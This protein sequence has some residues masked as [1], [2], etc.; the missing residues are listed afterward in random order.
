MLGL[1]A[2][3]A[4]PIVGVCIASGI[5]IHWMPAT[6]RLRRLVGTGRPKPTQAATWRRLVQRV[7]AGQR[8]NGHAGPP[9]APSVAG[10]HLLRQSGRIDLWRSVR[11][12]PTPRRATG[13]LEQL[14]FVV[15]GLVHRPPMLDVRKVVLYL[16]TAWVWLSRK[17]CGA[18]DLQK[19]SSSP[20]TRTTTYDS[21]SHREGIE[22]VDNT[23][24]MRRCRS[25]LG[26]S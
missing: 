22:R 9:P 17:V 3:F 11:T 23:S 6:T 14:Q 2:L 5:R 19:L 4:I 24:N 18:E 26:M 10:R 1:L 16:V 25:S 21:W 20:A 13:N 7:P 8:R 12:L 15:D